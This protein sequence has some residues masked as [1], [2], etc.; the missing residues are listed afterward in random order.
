MQL[1]ANMTVIALP[2][3]TIDL[4]FTAE[5]IM[6]VNLI[7]L[8][9]FVAFSIPFAKI[10]SQYGIKKSTKISIIAL[11]ISI[12]ISVF[13]VNGYMFLLSRMIQ[14][15]TSA[16]LAISIY[17][18]IV[19][20]FSDHELGT[21]LG[22]VS[23]AGYLGILIAPSFM[24]F[25]ML[26]LN[27]KLGFLILVPILLVLLYLLNKVEGEWT[28]EK[29]PIDN[30]GS[31]IYILLMAL[32]TYGVTVIDEY[33]I[34]LVLI[35][36]ILLAVLIKFEKTVKEPIIDFKLFRNVRYV[37]GNYGAMVS[38]FTTTIAV[39]VLSF[40]LQ[41]ILEFEEYVVGLILIIGP[42][43]MIGMSNIS[44]K[45]TNK[46]DPR[47]ISGIAMLFISFAMAIYFVMDFVPIEIILLACALQGIGSGMFSAPNNKYVLTIVDEEKL[48]DA[49]SILSTSKEFGKIL[50]TSIYTVILSAFIGNQNLG[51]DHLDYLLIQASNLMMFI[52]GLIALSAA[53]LLFYSKYRYELG[54]NPKIVE[55]FKSIA[56]DWIKNNK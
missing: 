37:I 56:P 24:G 4:N 32:F 1:I 52:C 31:L 27:W 38:Y 5:V 36:L 14:G 43:I 47:I 29:K 20:E 10:I 2:E 44:G 45:L 49:S 30:I 8:I 18:M 9:S 19:E 6:W 33:G 25:I 3:I 11:F 40:H 22:M 13:S 42:I 53:I 54:I 41:Y 21:A 50:S 55:I 34:F 23:S 12:L 16:S 35:S 26:I 28:S 51:P 7:Y 39:T 46:Y 17:V 15:F 48:A